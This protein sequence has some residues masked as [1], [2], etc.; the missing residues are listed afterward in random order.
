VDDGSALLN[1]SLDLALDKTS[2]SQAV[3]GFSREQEQRLA[4]A[5]ISRI[6][7]ELGV[8]AKAQTAID[9]QLLPYQQAKSVGDKD[10]YGVSL[11][12]HRAGQLRFALRQPVKA[13]QSFQRSAE[14]A[15]KLKNPVSA[16]M[17]VV[18]MAWALGRIPTGDPGYANFAKTVGRA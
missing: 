18:N 4:Q 11:I 2:G 10:L 13:F 14:L 9:Q 7:T 6:E 17:N 8:L 3:Y 1:V 5:F 15:F 12:S 16:A